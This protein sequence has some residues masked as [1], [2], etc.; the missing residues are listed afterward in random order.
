MRIH[1]D[2]ACFVTCNACVFLHHYSPSTSRCCS[3]Y[4]LYP[5]LLISLRCCLCSLGVLEMLHTLGLRGNRLTH[6]SMVPIFE[7]FSLRHLD[8]SV[9]SIAGPSLKVLCKRLRSKECKISS[10]ELVKTSIGY[11][12]V[13]DIANAIMVHETSWLMELS[14]AQ[15]N[16]NLQAMRELVRLLKYDGCALSWLD[17]ST[18]LPGSAWRRHSTLTSP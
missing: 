10:L 17:R 13:K 15:N 6:K 12:D 11:D 9:N 14:L 8:V 16:L 2:I 3:T 7:N 1:R 4:R 5:Y 18:P